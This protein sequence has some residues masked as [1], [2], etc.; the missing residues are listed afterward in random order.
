MAFTLEGE[1]L[2]EL[3][4]GSGSAMGQPT[5]ERRMERVLS[6]VPRSRNVVYFSDNIV[7]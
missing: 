7:N 5:F 3:V 1:M 2:Q 4:L 6:G